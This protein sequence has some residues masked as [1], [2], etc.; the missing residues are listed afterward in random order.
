LDEGYRLFTGLELD[1]EKFLERFPERAE[2]VSGT[3]VMNFCQHQIHEV[4]AARNRAA[5]G[6][7][8]AR[9][10]EQCDAELGGAPG[11]AGF[12]PAPSPF[13]QK[14]QSEFKHYA[15]DK[16]HQLE[17]GI[18]GIVEH[19]DRRI[20]PA[21]RVLSHFSAR[22]E[23]ELEQTPNL[24]Q[25]VRDR[26]DEIRERLGGVQTRSPSAGLRKHF[27]R[28]A[29]PNWHGCARASRACGSFSRARNP[30]SAKASVPV[31]VYRPT[32]SR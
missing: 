23:R 31:S 2:R 20:G 8:V 14:I 16:L 12:A 17:A 6:R 1:E 24:L 18:R 7:A 19:P 15:T 11:F 9:F 28:D 4:R 32:S 30:T 10:F 27:Q 5:F 26:R 29:L 3:D 22:V 13:E 21:E 25:S